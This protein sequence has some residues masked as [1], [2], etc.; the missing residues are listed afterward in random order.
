MF[1]DPKDLNRDLTYRD[2]YPNM[3]EDGIGYGPLLA[4]LAIVLIIGGLIAFAPSSNVQT[5]A[6]RPAIERTMPAPAPV[7]PV[8]RTTAPAGP[9]Q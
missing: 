4:L 3:T 8:P 2:R 5:A 6:N 9:Q 7:A 1:D